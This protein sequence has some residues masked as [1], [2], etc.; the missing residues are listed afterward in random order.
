MIDQKMLFQSELV[1]IRPALCRCCSQ[2]PRVWLGW[3]AGRGTLQI[4]PPS[5]SPSLS[6]S[7][8]SSL[9]AL[10]LFAVCIKNIEGKQR[11]TQ[12]FKP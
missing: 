12:I 2:Q 3:A 4:V 9:P 7:H 8:P 11:K 1:S 5:P 6:L 10:G